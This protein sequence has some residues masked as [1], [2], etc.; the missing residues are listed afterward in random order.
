MK[1]EHEMI[2]AIT[3]RDFFAS[4]AMQGLIPQFR[5]MFM[6][7]SIEGCWVGDAIP[8]LTKEAY[9]M[10]DAMIKARDAQA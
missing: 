9:Y 6:D 8:E 7:G 2:S 4:H 3:L 5:A 10:A 1:K